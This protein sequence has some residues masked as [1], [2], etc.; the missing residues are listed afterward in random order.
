[1]T[2]NL[3]YED[4]EDIFCQENLIIIK[5]HCE[6]EAAYTKIKQIVEK[7]DKKRLSFTFKVLEG[8]KHFNF[9]VTKENKLLKEISC[10]KASLKLLKILLN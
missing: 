7:M 10:W 4:F 1:M 5:H 3:Y 8:I 9:T 6:D 2:D